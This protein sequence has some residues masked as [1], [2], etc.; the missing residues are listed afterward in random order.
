LAKRYRVIIR[1]TRRGGR[2][3]HKL[4]DYEELPEPVS[5]PSMPEGRRIE[6]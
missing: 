2:E 4:L 3:R 1:I 5:L 6:L